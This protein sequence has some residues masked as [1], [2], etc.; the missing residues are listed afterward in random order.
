M[1]KDQQRALWAYERAAAARESGVLDDY[2]IAVQAFA[3]TLHRCGLA[4]AASVLERNRKHRG[5]GRLLNDIAGRPPVPNDH[6][7]AG[8]DRQGKDWPEH[9]RKMED[10]SLYMLTTRE[11]L[12]CVVW[13]RRAC[14][15]VGAD[16]PKDLEGEG[17][18]A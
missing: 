3:S 15:A 8:A 18:N 14:R 12:A 5:Y 2:E 6:E 13:L 1:R 7:R 4:V 16:A 10:V 9:V 17:G 11:V